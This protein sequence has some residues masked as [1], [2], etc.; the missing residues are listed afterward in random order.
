MRLA[1]VANVLA[2][3]PAPRAAEDIAD[4]KNIQESL[5]ATNIWRYG[6]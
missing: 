6:T 3:N 2:H 5:L 4:K 1:Q